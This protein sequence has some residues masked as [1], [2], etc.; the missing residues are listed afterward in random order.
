ME[1]LLAAAGT[2][3]D[4]LTSESKDRAQPKLNMLIKLMS[5]I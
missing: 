4:F 5:V 1:F 2:T 3:F